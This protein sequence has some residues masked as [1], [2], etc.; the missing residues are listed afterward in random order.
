MENKNQN[1]FVDRLLQDFLLG[2]IFLIIL[3]PFLKLYIWLTRPSDAKI[4]E[5][6]RK[7]GIL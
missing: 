5:Y 7:K 2:S 6:Y 1:S 4:K 3:Y